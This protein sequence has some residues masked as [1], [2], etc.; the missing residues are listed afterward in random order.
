MLFRRH[1]G[2]AAHRLQVDDRSISSFDMEDPQFRH[3]AA[4]LCKKCWRPFTDRDAFNNHLQQAC[5]NAS[6]SKREKYKLLQ[7]TFCPLVDNGERSLSSPDPTPL[8]GTG[9]IFSNVT[10]PRRS[11]AESNADMSEIISV[12]GD[13]PLAAPAPA[14]A[15]DDEEMVKMSDHVALRNRVDALEESNKELVL[16]N[17]KLVAFASYIMAQRRQGP[18]AA[19]SSS[20]PSRP[21]GHQTGQ[22]MTHQQSAPSTGPASMIPPSTTHQPATGQSRDKEG[23]LGGMNSQST[24]CD[25][26][27]D[28]DEDAQHILSTMPS[29][30]GS[31]HS[32][33]RHV[34]LTPSARFHR[35]FTDELESLPATE[36]QN[37]HNNNSNNNTAQSRGH[38]PKTSLTDSGYGSYNQRHLMVAAAQ[39]GHPVPIQAQA[40]QMDITQEHHYWPQYQPGEAAAVDFSPLTD[41]EGLEMISNM[42]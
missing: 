30:A 10:A 13:L 8:I 17:K 27:Q 37:I 38:R 4:G 28:F 7:D 35:N 39:E 14:T 20:T 16:S 3:P 9:P 32:T 18:S 22:P 25:D 15:I 40:P 41:E 11:I 34:P 29:V 26:E 24:D 12:A 21:A 31:E 36:A 1:F 5:A 42:D 19:G 23:L 6:R 2:R 33:L